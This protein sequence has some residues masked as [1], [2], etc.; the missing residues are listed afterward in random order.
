MQQLFQH[1]RFNIVM[2]PF[3]KFEKFS[4]YIQENELYHDS[5][6]VAINVADCITK[7]L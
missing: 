7:K 6:K 4:N 5:Y 1:S 2:K 3:M